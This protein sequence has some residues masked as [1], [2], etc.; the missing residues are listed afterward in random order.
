[1]WRIL[2]VGLVGFMVLTLAGCRRA[3]HELEPF[4]PAEEP[5]YGRPL[6]PGMLALRKISPEYYPDFS[7]GFHQ[8]AGLEDAIR[9]SLEYLAKPSSQRYYPYGDITHARVVASLQRF[10]ELL[11]DARS[12]AELDQAVRAEFDVYQSVGCDDQGTVYFTGYYCPIF[13]GRLQREGAFVYPLYGLPPDL[14]KDAEGQILGRRTP[15]GGLVPYYTRREIEAGGMLRGQEI[16]WLKD[17]FEAYVATVQGSAK[18]RLPDGR[19][20]ELGYAGNNG[21]EYTSVGMLMVDAGVIRRDELSLQSM[22]KYFA[23][24]P[25]DVERFCW[26]ND[27][28]AF[29]QER[30]G[31]PFGSLNVPVTRMRSIATDKA[32]FP[33][34][35]LTFIDTE[36]PI[37]YDGKVQTVPFGGFALDHDT[38]GAIRAAGRCDIY[39]GVGASAEAIAGRTGAE[40]A[41]Y[42]LFVK[43]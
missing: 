33:R 13:Q 6:P 25:R 16:A 20:Y 22:L 29:F 15:A 31:G 7:R 2:L 42:Y 21:H 32:V 10:L 39:M 11:R 38:G 34:A 43:Q 5:D 19:L 27:R 18:L 37:V 24:H 8:R 36:L 1:M 35:A 26:Q 14:V 23:A 4:R 17:P 3:T 41:L 28:Y 12:A 9:H 30:S 40:G